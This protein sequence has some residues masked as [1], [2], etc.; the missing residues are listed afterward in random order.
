M[1]CFTEE[2]EWVGEG[3]GF[4][5]TFTVEFDPVQYHNDV[6][7]ANTTIYPSFDIAIRR[8]AKENNFKS[9]LQSI[10]DA[11]LS[12]S[13]AGDTLPPWL[14]DT[15][16]GYGN[17]EESTFLSMNDRCIHTV[18]YRDTFLSKEHVTESFPDHSIEFRG[19]LPP[20]KVTF[21]SDESLKLACGTR[22]KTEQ[23]KMIVESIDCNRNGIHAVRGAG[24]TVRFTP[25]QVQA[26]SRALQPG[27]SLIVGPPGSGK[28]DVAVQILHGLY[29]NQSN[30]RTLIITHSNQALNDIFQKLSQKDI[31]IGKMLRLGYGENLLETEEEYDKLGRVNA[32]LRRRVELLMEIHA[33]AESL[34][35]QSIGEFTCETSASFWKMHVVPRWEK[36]LSGVTSDK[37]AGTIISEFPFLKYTSR[38]N[39][40]IDHEDS[41]N[42][43][44]AA[45]GVISSIFDELDDLRPFEVLT[46][47]RNR[48]NYMLTKQAKVIAMTCTHAAIKRQEFLDLGFS[49]DNILMEEAAQILDIESILP[50][51]MQQNREDSCRLKR[52]IMIGDHYQ[53]PPVVK[54]PLLKNHCRFEQSL[55]TRLIRL[56]TPYIQLN[57]QGRCRPS[58]ASLFNWRYRNLE[59]LPQT[60]MGEF[61]DANPG[62]AFDCQFVNVEDFLGKG[63]NQPTPYFYQNLGEAEYIVLQY[64][65]MRLLGYQA[66]KISILTTYNGQCQLLRDIIHQKCAGH[67]LFGMPGSVSTVD[68]YQ[69]QQNDF[70]LLS[71]VRTRH[72]GHLRD[73][74]RLVVALSRAR[75]GLYIF[76]RFDLFQ[77]CQELKPVFDQ[78]R[79]KPSHLALVEGE[80]S[81]MEITRPVSEV[82]L[83]SLLVQ[84]IS[85]MASIVKNMEAEWKRQNGM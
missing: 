39:I 83:K 4:K 19:T 34:K 15:L 14:T 11:L 67:P 79:E 1:N 13:I 37:E 69:G 27:L 61:A 6:L 35:V 53:L 48:I 5:R 72:V 71:L 58:L 73:V 46:S 20:F 23:C 45:F 47:Q 7:N 3:K 38:K 77:K 36:Y 18:D 51:T 78:L 42:S 30:E 49:F 64:Q 66:K 44:K 25:A 40:S 9:V 17:P 33:L 10:R 43:V 32:M 56:N 62:F 57:M 21:C 76:G 63:E 55:F 29:H 74:R 84:D 75:L 65:Y 2:G 68:K 26:I 54:N 81:K 85:H 59:N 8:D 80:H 31:S 70:V 60:S 41:I 16:L 52:L 50:L 28:T 22:V 24:N 82:P 12:E